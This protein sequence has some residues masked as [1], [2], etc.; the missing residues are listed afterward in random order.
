MA[1]A[2]KK[3]NIAPRQRRMI[4]DADYVPSA[5]TSS[6]PWVR[7]TRE[8]GHIS[9]VTVLPVFAV[10]TAVV[11]AVGWGGGDI[12]QPEEAPV[13]AREIDQAVV[14]DPL[15]TMSGVMPA[16]VPEEEYPRLGV[17]VRTVTA[18]VAEYYCQKEDTLVPGVQIYSLDDAGA[19]AL[20]GAQSGDIITA[21]EDREIVSEAELA[22][23]EELF[24]P[25][26]TVHLTVYRAGEY[27]VLETVFPE[28]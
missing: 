2:E 13:P 1:K 8:R 5:E 3:E 12:R 26:E 15:P 7:Q 4:Q 25:G 17:S 22:A 24:I 14:A 16:P 9:V 21:L 11:V 10:L 6:A 20:A 27:V 19:A 23:A 18:P 28:E